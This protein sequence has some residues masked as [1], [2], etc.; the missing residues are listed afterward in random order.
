MGREKKVCI[1]IV[2]LEDEAVPS[3]ISHFKGV[4]LTIGF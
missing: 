2:Y 4:F 3:S 1:S